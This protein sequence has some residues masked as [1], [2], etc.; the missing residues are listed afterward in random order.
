MPALGQGIGSHGAS[1]G[2]RFQFANERKFKATL[3]MNL[4]FIFSSRLPSHG[5]HVGS[6]CPSGQYGKAME[7]RIPALD[8]HL[9]LRRYP[10]W[11]RKPQLVA[12]VF[13]VDDVFPAMAAKGVQIDDSVSCH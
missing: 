13:F 8:L 9:V 10:V 1:S 2:G 6:D 3:R 11:M 7:A 4:D 5:G 12:S